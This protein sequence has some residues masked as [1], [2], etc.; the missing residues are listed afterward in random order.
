[1]QI[2]KNK[3]SLDNLIIFRNKSSCETWN[4]FFIDRVITCKVKG[5]PFSFWGQR[6]TKKYKITL[7]VQLNK[8]LIVLLPEPQLEC[9]LGEV[10][11]CPSAHS[12]ECIIPV[13]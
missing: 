3:R 1:M 10:V 9:F 7:Q 2:F 5:T 6:G 11:N 4:C 13:E 12:T 8:G